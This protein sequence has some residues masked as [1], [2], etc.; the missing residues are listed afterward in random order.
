MHYLAQLILHMST[1]WFMWTVHVYLQDTSCAPPCCFQDLVKLRGEKDGFDARLTRL[2]A[3]NE[4]IVK[5]MASLKVKFGQSMKLLRKYQVLLKLPYPIAIAASHR[6]G[7]WEARV[8][9]QAPRRILLT[10]Q[11]I[12]S[13]VSER[14]RIPSMF[15]VM[16]PPPIIRTSYK[17]VRQ[18]RGEGWPLRAAQLPMVQ[19]RRR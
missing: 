8:I 14:S 10:C 5:E 12:Y 7:P 15:F 2:R 4:D 1:M 6:V 16:R 18:P 17:R 3:Q 11:E 19:M 9:A 13:G